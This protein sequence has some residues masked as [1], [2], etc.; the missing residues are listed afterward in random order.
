[1]ALGLQ[2]NILPK[3]P[4]KIC[5]YDFFS[6]LIKGPERHVEKKKLSF[7]VFLIEFLELSFLNLA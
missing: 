1:M 2:R 3:I 4:K 5:F 7:N 6:L